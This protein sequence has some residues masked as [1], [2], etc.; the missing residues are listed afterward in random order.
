[1]EKEDKNQTTASSPGMVSC[2]VCCEPIKVGAEKC[3]HCSSYQDW[4]RYL[5]RWS[6]VLITL[7]GILPI[8]G[9]ASSLHKIAFSPN[10]ANIEAALISFSNDRKEITVAF[11]NSG[12]LDGI[13]TDVN[14]VLLQNGKRSETDYEVRPT[15]ELSGVVVSPNKPP[16]IV[17]YKA[18]IDKKVDT[19]F[20]PKSKSYPFALEINWENFKGTKKKIY[21]EYP[22]P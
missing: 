8:W 3:I 19:V 15:G 18:F 13:V 7:L 20:I 21:K 12:T 14:F 1:M 2:R 4:T 10:T 11:A 17:S 16:V 9:I 22:C 5:L 6:G